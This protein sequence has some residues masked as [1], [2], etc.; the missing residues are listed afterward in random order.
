VCH[1]QAQLLG[2]PTG[3]GDDVGQLLGGELAGAT[4]SLVIG[5]YPDDRFVQLVIGDVLGAGRGELVVGGG[6]AL[7]PSRY[8]LC[9]GADLRRDDD[10]GLARG[11]AKHD[12][13]A[14]GKPSL[15]GASTRK[16]LQDA[17][18]ARK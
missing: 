8:P 12:V 13:H 9:I 16:L 18:L 2:L 10:V 5:E 14:L 6:E 17:A 4:A 1:W 11:S 7:A 15:D 3:Q